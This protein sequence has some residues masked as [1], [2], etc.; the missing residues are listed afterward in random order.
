MRLNWSACC[1]LFSNYTIYD[2]K[3]QVGCSILVII[4]SVRRKKK[5]TEK[6]AGSSW[7]ALWFRWFV[8]IHFFSFCY[9]FLSVSSLTHIFEMS[10]F[11]S[12]C[13]YHSVYWPIKILCNNFVCVCVRAF[14]LHK[15]NW[16]LHSLI[17]FVWE[18]QFIVIWHE[19]FA[20]R[21]SPSSQLKRR[22]TVTHTS[23]LCCVLYTNGNNLFLQSHEN[24]FFSD[25]VVVVVAAAVVLVAGVYVFVCKF[26]IFFH[27][28]VLTQKYYIIYLSHVNY[29]SFR[30]YLFYALTA[31]FERLSQHFH[32]NS[33][34]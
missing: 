6:N 23:I 21:R 20:Q 3:Y 2:Y 22:P 1:F 18:K 11:S 31:K 28:F 34:Q 29:F 16:R 12:F 5:G 24:T 26:S 30:I 4:D 25:V 14:L 13:A 15:F 8:C 27:R 32:Y 17:L 9:F 19:I 10:Y 7:C 33:D